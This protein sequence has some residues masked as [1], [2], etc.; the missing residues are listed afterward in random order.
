[1][2]Y[3]IVT[4]LWMPADLAHGA[5]GCEGGGNDAVPGVRVHGDRAA[6]GRGHHVLDQVP[7]GGLHHVRGLDT[8]VNKG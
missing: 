5:V 7:R 6:R 4:G 8:V 3:S 2:K 1:M